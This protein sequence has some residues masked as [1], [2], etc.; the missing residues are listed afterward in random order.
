MKLAFDRSARTMDPDGRLHVHK[1]HISK[2][3]VNP[4]YG[5]EIPRWDEL[6]LDPDK[7]YQL[8]RDP[9]EL[10]RGAQTFARLPILEV[11]KHITVDSML[12]NPDEKGHIIGA[13]GSDIAFEPPYLDADLCFWDGK[14]IAGVESGE[15][16][17]LSCA[18]RYDALMEPG[19][20]EGVA[21]DGRMTNIVGSHLALVVDGRAG[22]DVIVAD[23]NP[24]TKED[25]VMKMTK[26]GKAMFLALSA[27]SPV[28]AADSALPALVGNADRKTFKKLNVKA[29]IVAMDEDLEPEK[30]DN[31]IDALLDVEQDPNPM[32]LS[33]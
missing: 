22:P 6:G 30:V 15:V 8:F 14:A 4:Y 24:F 29:K 3:T 12:E 2:A 11:H 23:Q 18:Y 19:E 26:L 33:K 10:E 16:Q 17:E 20:H 28:L 9:V 27:M 1:S 21:Y 32:V 13:I 31:V 5:R 25:T 7:I